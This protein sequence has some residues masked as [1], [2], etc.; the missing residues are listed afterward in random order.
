M[1]LA[2]AALRALFGDAARPLAL[3]A[4]RWIDTRQASSAR[5]LA[6]PGASSCGRTGRSRWLVFFVDE[7]AAALT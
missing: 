1:S 2:I 5:T 4:A 7:A 3:W 6:A